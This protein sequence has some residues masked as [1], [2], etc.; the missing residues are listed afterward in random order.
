MHRPRVSDIIYTIDSNKLEYGCRGL[1]YGSNSNRGLIW[2]YAFASTPEKWN[3]GLYDLGWFYFFS[4][5]WGWRM[6]MFQL[7]VFYRRLT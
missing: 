2:N 3:M 5:P 4:S 1:E 7:S 6:V